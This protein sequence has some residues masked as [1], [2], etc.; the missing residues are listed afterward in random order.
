M[1]AERKRRGGRFLMIRRPP[2]KPETLRDR[3]VVVM[4]TQ[5]DYATLERLAAREGLAPGTVAY[6]LL[7][8]ALKRRK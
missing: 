3:R 6:Q 1:T 2:R 7:M 5:A 8:G 4:V